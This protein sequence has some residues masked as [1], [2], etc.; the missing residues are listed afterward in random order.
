MKKI[1]SWFQIPAINIERSTA[2]YGVVLGVTFQHQED[3]IGRH[4]FFVLESMDGDLTGG[5]IIQS[6]YNQPS[7]AGGVTLFLNASNGIATTLAAVEKSGGK[8]VMPKMD[9]GG[10]GFIAMITDSEGNAIGLHSVKP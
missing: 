7:A 4:A 6:P 8:V 5:E 3:Q 9:L 1:I 2:F 10:H